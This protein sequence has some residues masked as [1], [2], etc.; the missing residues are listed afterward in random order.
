ME[1]IYAEARKGS[2]DKILNVFC[3]FGAT[4]SILADAHPHVE[5]ISCL[6]LS[7]YTESDLACGGE[8]HFET[9]MDAP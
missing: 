2:V 3:Q 8:V 7:K 6:L 9:R 1:T 4:S 5:R